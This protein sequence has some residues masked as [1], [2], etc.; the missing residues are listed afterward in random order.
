MEQQPDR[1]CGGPPWTKEDGPPWLR[2]W[3]R[4]RA[5]ARVPWSSTLLVAVFVLVGTA[6]AA[7]GQEG[8]R[9]SVD[10][11]A[12]TL[13]VTASACLLLRVRWPVAALVGTAALASV[14]LAAGYPYGPVFVPVLVA[15][16]SAVVAGHRRAAWWTAGAFW[17]GHV[18]LAH[19]WYAYL[20]PSGDGAAPWERELV[21]AAWIAAVL[22]GS[23]LLRI[24]RAEWVRAQVERAAAARRRAEEE[25]LLIARELHDVLAHSI[26]VINVQAGVGLALLDQNPEQARAALTTIKAA[27]KEALGEVRQVL[28]SLRAPGEAPRAPAPGLDRVPELVEQARSASLAVAVET[29]GTPF[30]LPPGTDLAAFRILQEALT[31]VVRHSGSRTARVLISY[32]PGR[33]TLRVADDGPASGSDTGGSGNGLVGM[34]E[35]AAGLGGT[36]QAGPRHEGGFEVCADLPVRRKETV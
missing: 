1:V 19:W 2:S 20:P 22:A 26:S 36:I 33:L 13:L 35:R 8:T 17:A 11:L 16:F 10:A 25:R 29:R 23:E 34:R 6:F 12:R 31:N 15:A 9:E 21:F 32:A 27:S 28:D 5:D 18:L 24:R 14:Y 30:A 3:A 7:R 4:R